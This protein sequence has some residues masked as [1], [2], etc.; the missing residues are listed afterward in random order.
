MLFTTCN[1]SNSEDPSLKY[2]FGVHAI[3]FYELVGVLWLLLQ[4]RPT[5]AIVTFHQV[6]LGT[7]LLTL[8]LAYGG[9]VSGILPWTNA[10]STRLFTCYSAACVSSAWTIVTHPNLQWSGTVKW[11]IPANSIFYAAVRGCTSLAVSSNKNRVLDS[12]FSHSPCIFL[13][14]HSIIH[15]D[16]WRSSLTRIQSCHGI[17]S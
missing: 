1:E 7:S 10:M 15:G 16:T 3:V 14:G 13:L 4:V 9:V 11:S 17:P 2:G 5:A 12:L 8:G 6:L